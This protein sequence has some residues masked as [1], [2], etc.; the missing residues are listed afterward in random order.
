MTTPTAKPL[1]AGMRWGGRALDKPAW[2]SN[3][4]TQLRHQICS[5]QYSPHPCVPVHPTCIADLIQPQNAL[6]HNLCLADCD[7][8]HITITHHT[9]NTIHTARSYFNVS[10]LAC[11]HHTPTNHTCLF[12][13]LFAWFCSHLLLL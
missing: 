4:D 5:Q 7:L 10:F 1:Q 11:P 12:S 8:Y 13:C 3:Q 2:P 9:S 6:D